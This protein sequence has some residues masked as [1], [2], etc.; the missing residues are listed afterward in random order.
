MNKG[1]ANLIIK[2]SQLLNVMK[3]RSVLLGGCIL[4]CALYVFS[5]VIPHPLMAQ[6]AANKRLLDV[7][8]RLV[9]VGSEEPTDENKVYQL[10]NATWLTVYIENR[11]NQRLKLS[12]LDPEYAFRLQLYKDDVEVPYTDEITNFVRSKEENPKQVYIESDRFIE[13][14][15]TYGLQNIK[16]GNWYGPLYPGK[17]RLIV[18][19]RLELAGPWTANSPPMLFEILPKTTPDA[20]AKDRPLLRRKPSKRPTSLR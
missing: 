5:Q 8:V 10:D 17:Y 19:R 12:V 2:F 18:H 16:L 9:P 14:K 11:S 13:P 6:L 4:A 7:T 20:P 1:F 15:T 3:I